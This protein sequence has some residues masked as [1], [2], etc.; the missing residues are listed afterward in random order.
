MYK[1]L[2]YV[3]L[4]KNCKILNF[5]PPPKKLPL[6]LKAQKWQIFINSQ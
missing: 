5:E 6:Q 2:R 1:T 3:F 4:I